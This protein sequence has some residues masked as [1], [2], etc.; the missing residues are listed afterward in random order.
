[1]ATGSRHPSRDDGFLGLIDAHTLRAGY[2]TVQAI[3]VHADAAA[4]RR[5]QLRRRS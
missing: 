4:W 5:E 3:T 1:M 2:A